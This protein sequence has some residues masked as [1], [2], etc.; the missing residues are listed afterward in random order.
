MKIITLLSVFARGDAVSNDALAIH[1]F[2][3]K[4]GYTTLMA[5]E[6]VCYQPGDVEVISAD[7]LSFIEPEDVVIYH[8]STGTKLN[9]QI[10]QTVCTLIIRYHNVTPANFFEGYSHL[11]VATALEGIRGAEYLADK[12]D[13]CI[14]DSEFNKNDL[15]AMGYQCPME[16]VPILIPFDD[17]DKKPDEELLQKLKKG[18]TNIVFTGRIVPNKKQEDIILAFFLYQKYYDAD[19]KLHLVG[20][21][22]GFE[23]YYQKLLT[24][25]DKLGVKNVNFTGHISFAQILAYYRAAD[26]FLCMSDH[27]GFCVPLIEAMKFDVPVI[28][29]DTTAIARTLGMGGLLL[30][31]AAPQMAAGLMHKV[32]TDQE[33]Q[34]KMVKNGQERLRDFAHDKIGARWLELVKEIVSQ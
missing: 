3:T 20:N 24:Y 17:Y 33:L 32:L 13:L 27:E 26:L 23:S 6:T 8:L 14:C 25:V 19:A 5:A 34:E 22:V 29:K 16:V 1:R 9:Y 18:G 10:G 28:A 21:Y 30:P 31:D 2:L 15:L 11:K 4:N 12:A 7:K